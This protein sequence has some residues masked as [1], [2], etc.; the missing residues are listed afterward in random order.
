MTGVNFENDVT[1]SRFCAHKP[2][3]NSG[4]LTR[5]AGATANNVVV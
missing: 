2:P 3:G 1:F 5:Y 4:H